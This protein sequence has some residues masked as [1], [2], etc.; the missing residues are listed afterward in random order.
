MDID[1]EDPKEDQDMDF[2][3][4]DEIREWEDDKDWLIALV[5]PSRA[6]TPFRPNTQPLLFATSTPLP[7]DPIMLPDHQT[8]TT[9]PTP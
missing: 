3:D 4:D 2:K 8:T 1:K 7:I 6:T 9:I 5:T